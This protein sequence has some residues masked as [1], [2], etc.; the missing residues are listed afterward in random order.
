MKHVQKLALVATVVVAAGIVF[1]LK[2]RPEAP[3]DV[4][5]ATAPAPVAALPRLVD[6]GADKCIPCRMMAPVLE[7][8]KTAYAGRLQVEFIDVWK[9]PEAGEPYGIRSIPT[10]IFLA[11]DGRELYRHEGFFA[12]DDIVAKWKELG[13]EF[14]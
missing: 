14:P 7:E 3:A 10:Q 11:A 9:N 13:Y 5:P 2:P 4:V 12:R 8:L 1:A 6:L